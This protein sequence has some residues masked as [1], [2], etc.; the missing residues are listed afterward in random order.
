MSLL[1]IYAIIVT[2]IAVLA[3]WI[4]IPAVNAWWASHKQAIKDAE[5]RVIATV[6]HLKAATQTDTKALEARVAAVEA[7]LKAKA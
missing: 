2:I 4:S 5:A 6:E 1:Q 7:Q 3:L